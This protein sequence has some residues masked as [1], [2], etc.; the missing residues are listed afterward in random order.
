MLTRCLQP[1]NNVEQLLCLTPLQKARHALRVALKKAAQ[2]ILSQDSSKQLF[3]T[4]V[5]YEGNVNHNY[6]RY[7]KKT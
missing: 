4:Q 3:S 2:E 5:D 7:K 6:T 1:F